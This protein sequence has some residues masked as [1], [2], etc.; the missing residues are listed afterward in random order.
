MGERWYSTGVEELGA[1][2][3]DCRRLP[4]VGWKRSEE[5]EQDTG[6]DRGPQSMSV[7]QNKEDLIDLL[8]TF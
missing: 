6:G 1:W 4:G 5:G 3:G 2:A 8:V 7:L